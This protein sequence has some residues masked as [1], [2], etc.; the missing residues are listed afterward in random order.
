MW[1][2]TRD[3]P[4]G[5]DSRTNDNHDYSTDSTEIQKTDLDKLL[6]KFKNIFNDLPGRTHLGTHKILVKPDIQQVKCKHT[7]CTRINQKY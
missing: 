4:F 1:F 2:S 6:S 7:E 5:E 3:T